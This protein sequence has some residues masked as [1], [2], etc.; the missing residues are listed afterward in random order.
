MYNIITYQESYWLQTT[1]PT[2]KRS[3]LTLVP[4]YSDH[5][6][7]IAFQS[8]KYLHICW[9]SSADSFDGCHR[10]FLDHSTETC[11]HRREFP[12][13][14]SGSLGIWSWKRFSFITSLWFTTCC[15]ERKRSG[16]CVVMFFKLGYCFIQWELKRNTSRRWCRDWKHLE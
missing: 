10:L 14:S 13:S 1:R 11:C 2:R 7:K 12:H 3:D 16:Q 6:F 9:C 4:N 5:E 8:R 15:E